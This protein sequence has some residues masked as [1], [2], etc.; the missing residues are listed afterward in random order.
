MK[1]GCTYIKVSNME[2]SIDFYSKLLNQQPKY[3]NKERWV[4][5][6]CGNTLA[7]YNLQYDIDM[8]SRN[9]NLGYHY[10][11]AYIKYLKQE[12]TGGTKTVAFNFTVDDLRKEYERIRNL[13]IGDVSDIMYVNITMPYYF[14]IVNDPDGNEIEITGK[15][16]G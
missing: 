1:F 5:F 10:N 7:L 11:D 4:M 6:H 2:K 9:E 8:L 3:S 14:F 16:S 15:F 12:S 13:G